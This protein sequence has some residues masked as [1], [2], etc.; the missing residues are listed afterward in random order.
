[1]D[2]SWIGLERCDER[3]IRGIGDF[4]EFVKHN[5]L[6][7]LHLCP[8]RRCKLHNRIRLVT[9]DEMHGHLILNGMM[10]DYVTWTSHGEVSS[11]PSVY[12]LRQQYV[13][14]RS[15]ETGSSSGTR[16]AYN[17]NPSMEILSDAFPFRDMYGMGAQGMDED[18]AHDDPIV[19]EA[20]EKY[21]RLLS[22][23]QTPLHVGSNTTVLDTILSAMQLKVDNGWSDKS[24]DGMLRYAK[25]LL[26]TDNNHPT[27]YR[28][29]KKILKNLGLS[30]ET[31]H[32]CEYGCILYY[33]EFENLCSC[34]VCNEPRY[35][36]SDHMTRVPKKVVKYFPLT[37][38]LQRLYMSS[39]IAK[40]MRWHAHRR[41]S[42]DGII[43]HPADGKAWQD[44]NKEFPSFASEIRNVRLGLST[45]GFNP[46]GAAGLSHST[47][48]IV[49][50]P[51][52]LPPSM[53]MKK[54]FNILT[55]LIS[56]PK[57][58]G[59]CLNVFMRPLIDELNTLWNEGVVTFDRYDG[60]SFLMKAAVIWTISDFPGLGMLGGLKTKGYK[61][62]PLCL[63]EVDAEHIKGR[64][65]YQGHRRWLD[66]NH[67]WRRAPQKFN[68][69]IE[70][71]DAPPS[72]SG[73]E[74]LSKI[75]SHEYPALSLHPDLKNRG[76]TERLCWTHVSIFYDLPYW[77]FL[78]QPYSLDV[79]H[80]EKN[81]FDNILGTI[82]GLEGKTKDDVRA[83]DGLQQ[84]NVR[85]HLWIKRNG[86][87]SNKDKISQA[88]YTV[89][90]EQRREILEWIKD[91]KYPHG[92]AGSLK[93]KINVNEKKFIGLKTHDCHVMLQCL[94]PVFIR[95]Y[96][97]SQVVTPLI[98]LSKWF[99]KLCCRELKANDVVEM[100][101]EIFMILCKLEMIF[102]PAFFTIMVHLMIHLPDQVLL[103]GPVHFSWMYPIERQLG[104]Y[105]RS[106]RN[107][108]YPEGCIA[109]QYIAQECVNFCKLYIGDSSNNAPTEDGSNCEPRF[110]ISVVSDLVKPSGYLSR[111]K[112]NREQIEI[113]HWCVM[114]HCKEASYYICKHKDKIE[115]ECPNYGDQ[116]RI[117]HFHPYF[118]GWMEKLQNTGHPDYDHELHILSCFPQAYN[119]YSQCHLNGVKFVVWDRDQKMTTQ[120]SGV[121][122]EEVACD[123]EQTKTTRYYGILEKVIELIY[124]DGLPVVLFECKWFNTDPFENGTKLD[125]GLLSIDTS[126]TW[127][128][129]SPYCLATTARQV[130]Y[131]EDPKAGDNW[132]IVNVVSHRGIYSDFS[133]GRDQNSRVAQD[134]DI[135][136]EDEYDRDMHPNI[137]QDYDDDA[138]DDEEGGYA[139][140][141][142]DGD[143]I[144]LGCEETEDEDEHY[145]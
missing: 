45:D 11:G 130:F 58:P 119:C 63:D 134:D 117:R 62:C 20:Y 44:F 57:S 127:Y 47:W 29:I 46:F 53:S 84:L 77:K 99:Q 38:R 94:L 66:K 34:P 76:T 136:Q 140:R 82:L 78:S 111:A 141:D 37:P 91:V 73:I 5:K 79:M 108:R 27:S 18:V 125:H 33:K 40:E 124:A 107:T 90:P 83:R 22:E 89:L 6:E 145:N 137:S 31:I 122:V 67:P 65:S 24:F 17:T 131:L 104:E 52:N 39:H 132:K 81:V 21:H 86:S 101:M 85:E 95:P 36:H 115:R 93:G 121:M 112:L 100:K 13:L 72:I 116:D 102:P 3:Y 4:I 70:S 71:R 55:M 113:A 143:E 2:K 8:C 16:G 50:M 74:V 139:Y 41:T 97:P 12:M 7:A 30:Y 15:G 28:D 128:E 133:I 87:S 118:R 23:A 75:L 138:M 144:S 120:N 19:K 98:A 9:L 56:G 129:G 103:K 61:A 43:R 59:K 1:M 126:S 80:I 32:A 135:Y 142:E 105:K 110:K 96:L 14:D 64:M 42:N 10:R 35:V 26:P 48:P 114:E 51:Y 68:G 49:V 69:T 92:Y 123:K 54:E 25:K 88:P 60:S 109:E 106:V